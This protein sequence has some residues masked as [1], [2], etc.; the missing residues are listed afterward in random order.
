MQ[1]NLDLTYPIIKINFTS[2]SKIAELDKQ[3]CEA[4]LDSIFEDIRKLIT[5]NTKSITIDL[6]LF[7][8][9]KVQD[10]KAEHIQLE[11]PKVAPNDPGR[12]LTI[13][14]LL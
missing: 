5:A 13:K 8:K 14:S 11:K 3:L 9:L 10:K 4:I 12:K 6:S 7:G 2:L 1:Q